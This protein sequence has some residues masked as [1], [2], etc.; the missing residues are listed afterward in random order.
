MD[1]SLVIAVTD[2]PVELRLGVPAAERARAQQVTVTVRL[3]RPAP[4]PFAPADRIGRTLDYDRLIDFI[5][6]GLPAQGPFVLVEAVADAVAAHALALAGAGARVE[7]TVA[8][9]SVLDAPAQ[10]SI[11]L[12][13]ERAP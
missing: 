1:L 11:T 9:P 7:V 3:T 6:E 13:R 8:K 12:V 5:R 4:A 2:V 10:V